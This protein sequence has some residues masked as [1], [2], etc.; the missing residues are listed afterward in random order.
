MGRVK[1]QLEAVQTLKALGA[2]EAEA[3]NAF[4]TL[5]SIANDSE[6]ASDLRSRAVWCKDE[7]QRNPTDIPRREALMFQATALANKYAP[8]AP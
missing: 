2:S 6:C 8:T 7:L 1:K 5:E 3:K 4:A